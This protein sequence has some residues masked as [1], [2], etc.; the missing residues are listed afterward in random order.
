MNSILDGQLP[1][2]TNCTFNSLIES[3]C[4]N[5]KCIQF[6][7]NDLTPIDKSKLVLRN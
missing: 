7:N 6:K 1:L 3:Y 4:I 2:G 5:G